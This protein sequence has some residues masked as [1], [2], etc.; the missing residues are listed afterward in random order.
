MGED[1]AHP[2]IANQT[3][4]VTTATTAATTTTSRG[5]C[6][7]AKHCV[8]VLLHIDA[9]DVAPSGNPTS[10][11]G[12]RLLTCHPL[13]SDIL[14]RS[15]QPDV[16]TQPVKAPRQT[17]ERSRLAPRSAI[18]QVGS[19][20]IFSADKEAARQWKRRIEKM[21][22]KAKPQP[23]GGGRGGGGKM[24]RSRRTDLCRYMLQL[25]EPAGNE[26]NAEG[27]ARQ[28][29]VVFPSGPNALPTALPPLPAKHHTPPP[30][31]E[32][33]WLDYD[34]LS[35]SFVGNAQNVGG[36]GACQLPPSRKAWTTALGRAARYPPPRAPVVQ[37][38]KGMPLASPFGP[39]AFAS[40]W[41]EETRRKRVV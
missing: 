21:G 35:G 8:H 36:G 30:L 39:A 10:P 23:S 31:P 40:L 12:S 22:R 1:E 26:A 4:A 24:V 34:A 25:P 16:Q 17:T 9:L 14:V 20:R 18:S 19:T 6:S 41:M 5:S 3:T 13:Y 11:T 15:L 28:S 2:T 33:C 7:T 37:A 38:A 32:D 27:S 29:L